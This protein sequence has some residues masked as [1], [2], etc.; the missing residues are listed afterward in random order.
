MENTL[1][2]TTLQIENLKC[3]G[4]GSSVKNGLKKIEGVCDVTIDFATN[5][6]F[7][8]HTEEVEKADLAATLRG[9]GYPEVGSVEGFSAVTANLKS[10]VS[11]AVGRMSNEN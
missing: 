4:C 3:G 11:C 1:I 9:L 8:A 5:E 7:V 10:F 6:V 2:N